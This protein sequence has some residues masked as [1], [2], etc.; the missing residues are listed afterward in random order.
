MLHQKSL[1]GRRRETNT[2]RQLFV[3][4]DLLTTN[5][6][7]FLGSVKAIFGVILAPVQALSTSSLQVLP[8]TV[9]GQHIPHPQGQV[10]SPPLLEGA[11]PD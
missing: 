7:P 6:R 10:D 3:K 4:I 1:I 9:K 5:Y 8:T 11:D 2:M